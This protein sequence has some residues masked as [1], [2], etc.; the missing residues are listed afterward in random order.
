MFLFLTLLGIILKPPGFLASPADCPPG[1]FSIENAT[2]SSCYFLR[3]ISEGAFS[4]LEAANY[5]GERNMFL[6]TP[7]SLDELTAISSWVVEQGIPM[8][9]LAGPIKYV[10]MSY[11]DI[12]P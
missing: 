5:C 4:W 6:P 11:P 10:H 12:Y 3:D 9:S 2:P 8:N 1:M 7:Q